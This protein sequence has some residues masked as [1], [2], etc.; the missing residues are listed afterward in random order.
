MYRY[1]DTPRRLQ[2]Y[3]VPLYI[4]RLEKSHFQKRSLL[5]SGLLIGLV[6]LGSLPCGL[7]FLPTAFLSKF[8]FTWGAEGT[9]CVSMRLLYIS[10]F[11]SFINSSQKSLNL[12]LKEIQEFRVFEYVCLEYNYHA[13][14]CEGRPIHTLMVFLVAA[15]SVLWVFS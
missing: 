6:A 9:K 11:L 13:N 4:I 5:I 3:Q 7:L 1:T 10:S 15:A 14:E 12:R 8:L 2:A